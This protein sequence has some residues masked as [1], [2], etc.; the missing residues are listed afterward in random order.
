MNVVF[1]YTQGELSE[2][3]NDECKMPGGLR[4]ASGDKVCKLLKLI[5]SLK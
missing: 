4:E 5:Y 3:L 2:E 1:V